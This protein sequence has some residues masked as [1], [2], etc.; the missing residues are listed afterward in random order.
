[1]NKEKVITKNG[2]KSGLSLEFGAMLMTKFEEVQKT[3]KAVFVGLEP[4]S[5]LVIRLLGVGGIQDFL[6]EGTKVVVK[7]VSTGVVYG[8]HSTVVGYFFRKNMLLVLLSYPETIE[9][10]VLRKEQRIAC[11]IPA[12]II[13]P[14]FR[15]NGFL[16]DISSS[17]GRFAFPQTSPKSKPPIE[18]EQLVTL[19]FQLLGVEGPQDSVCRVR[20][21]SQEGRNVSV[22][23]QFEKVEEPIEENIRNYVEQVSQFLIEK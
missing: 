7:Y 10:F 19:S 6:Y 18:L 3:L 21:L 4:R 9:T 1:M 2:P 16:L 17:G 22:G 15:V 12:T 14:E 5:Y 20:G 8:F 11:Y 13:S 23:L